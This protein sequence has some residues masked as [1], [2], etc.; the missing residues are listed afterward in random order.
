MYG[1]DCNR[2]VPGMNLGHEPRY[3]KS[4]ATGDIGRDGYRLIGRAPRVH[5]AD[6]VDPA[7]AERI[8]TMMSEIP[9]YDDN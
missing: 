2:P 1:R 4:E 8:E 7:R 6:P 3:T 5:G 9:D